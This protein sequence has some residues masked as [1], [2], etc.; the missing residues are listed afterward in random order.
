MNESTVQPTEVTQ[1]VKAKGI[2]NRYVSISYDI[3]NGTLRSHIAR[4]LL[5]HGFARIN[6]SVYYGIYNEEL[7]TE[8]TQFIDMWQ[9]KYAKRGEMIDIWILTPMY[10]GHEAVQVLDKYEAAF[11]GEWDEVD[12]TFLRISK[13]LDI[14]KL[15][16]EKVELTNPQTGLRRY[17]WQINV[18]EFHH[19]YGP[20]EMLP[21]DF[22]KKAKEEGLIYHDKSD[23][24]WTAYSGDKIMTMV[25]RV[26]TGIETLKQGLSSRKK[27]E[28]KTATPEQLNNFDVLEQRLE[29]DGEYVKTLADRCARRTSR[30]VR[31]SVGQQVIDQSDNKGFTEE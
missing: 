30:E 26:Q 4:K 12:K 14:D 18:K 5:S 24:S 8:I 9:S 20:P 21:E 1:G 2:P 31:E 22:L 13:I 29:R 15:P 10:E 19:L 25:K 23:D 7:L 28:A 27:Y 11:R 6:L 16:M 3:S 17:V